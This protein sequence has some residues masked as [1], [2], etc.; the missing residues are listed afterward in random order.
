MPP[1]FSVVL[2]V[3]PELVRFLIALRIP[4]GRSLRVSSWWR[5]PTHNQEVGGHPRSQHLLG[6]AIDVTGDIDELA[7]FA[8]NASLKGLVPIMEGTHLHIQAR[9]AGYFDALLRA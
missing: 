9:P 2:R 3:L 4:A 1:P 7:A 8:R 6:L 5:S